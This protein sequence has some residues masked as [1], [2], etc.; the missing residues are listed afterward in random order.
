M[1]NPLS[2]CGEESNSLV[3]ACERLVFSLFAAISINY[4]NNNWINCT[5]DLLHVNSYSLNIPAQIWHIFANV[6][7]RSTTFDTKI[8]R[9]KM[10]R[11]IVIVWNVRQWLMSRMTYA[12]T[13]THSATMHTGNK[14]H[15]NPMSFA[16]FNHSRTRHDFE[17]HVDS[18]TN[19]YLNI[20]INK[21]DYIAHQCR[22]SHSKMKSSCRS[23][24]TEKLWFFICFC[25]PVSSNAIWFVIKILCWKPFS[26]WNTMLIQ[27]LTPTAL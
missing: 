13:S 25:L 18:M 5:K 19:G 10:P 4:I 9:K 11:S 14:I 23:N 1:K 3:N 15:Q 8:E 21:T 17:Y 7:Q 22:L 6:R 16:P 27:T 2:Q 24:A 12:Y 20:F 26:K